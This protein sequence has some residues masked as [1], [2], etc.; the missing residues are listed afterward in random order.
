MEAHQTA[1]VV[2]VD[3]QYLEPEH[4]AAYLLVEEGKAAFVEN[5][6]VHA[7][8]LLL[9]ALEGHG[10]VPSQVEY[11]IITHLHLDH[12]GGTWSLAEHCPEATVLAH[13]RAVRH[14]IDP[15]RLIAGATKVY[16]EAEFERLYAPIRPVDA[17]RIRGI[18]DG[19]SVVLGSRL[20]TFLHTR[21]HANHHICIYDS[22][23]NGVF[24]GDAFGIN[25]R[26]SRP[27]TQ[28]FL[29]Y[30]TA[31]PDFDP[32]EARASI[33]RI[34][35]TGASRLYPTHF[36]EL[37]AVKDA[38]EVVLK[39]IDQMEEILHTVIDSRLTGVELEQFC[40]GLVYDAIQALARSC[41]TQFES[42]AEQLL[43]VD[44]RIN[45]QG[46]VHLAR[47]HKATG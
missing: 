30:S 44:T 11:I 22:R 25:Y 34:L 5:N 45:A 23:S 24:T 18:E 35:A 8:P 1:P 40:E 46:L 32:A 36:G 26:A 9:Q 28:P 42:G 7:V 13:P 16:G 14:L 29:M 31:P 3:C 20:L 15:S 6:T 27:T 43:R 41:G 21:G 39:S 47:Q 38:A 37:T 2:T 33:R 19:E 12:A 10:L 4:A 17:S